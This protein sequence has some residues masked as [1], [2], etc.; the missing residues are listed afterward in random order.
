MA[1]TAIREQ[2]KTRKKEN[3]DY[4]YFAV[5]IFRTRITRKITN[6]RNS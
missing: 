3:K 4:A 6:K 1:E 5:N 2:Q